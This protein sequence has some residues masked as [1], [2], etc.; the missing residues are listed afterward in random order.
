MLG[1]VKIIIKLGGEQQIG[2]HCGL[3]CL[4][5]SNLNNVIRDEVILRCPSVCKVPSCTVQD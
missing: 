3:R 2:D 4:M 5:F 1:D